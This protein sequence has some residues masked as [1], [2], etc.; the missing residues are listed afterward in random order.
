MSRS[1]DRSAIVYVLWN[2]GSDGFGL[3]TIRSGSA[4]RR[5]ADNAAGLGASE[6]SGHRRGFPA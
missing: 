4:E 1:F 2:A 5:I 6:L 3:C